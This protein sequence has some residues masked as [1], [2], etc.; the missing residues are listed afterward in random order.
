MTTAIQ[1][2]FPPGPKRRFPGEFLLKMRQDAPAALTE[3]ASQ[4][5]AIGLGLG[6]FK[7][8][9]LSQPQWIHEVMVTRAHEFGKGAGQ[10]VLKRLLGDGLLTS[11]GE[12]HRQQ[13]QLMQPVFQAQRVG[14]FAPQMLGC[15]NYLLSHWPREQGIISAGDEMTRLT[16]Q[17]V[18][19]CLFGSD[20]HQEVGAVRQSLAEAMSLFRTAN[21]P[22][23]H[24]LELLVPSLKQRFEKSRQVLDEVILK[25]I[26][27][28]HRCPKDDLLSRMM[29]SGMSPQLLRDEAMTLFLAGHETTAHA[30]TFA[31]Y[32]LAR[33][34]QI[35][36]Q[37]RSEIDS[38]CGTR[39]L[40][41]EDLPALTD[42]KAALMETLRLY[43]TA[44][45]IGRRALQ[46]VVIGDILVPKDCTV[47]ISQY[48]MHRHPSYFAE[49]ELFWPTR[50][51]HTPRNQLPKG[52]YFPFGAGPRVCIGEHFAWLEML[53]GLGTILQNYQLLD[54]PVD[55][56][57]LKSQV[58]L[59]S[60]Q[61]LP[62]TVRKIRP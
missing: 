7:L 39:P 46:D 47:L 24:W 33:N 43:P 62:I 58:T 23:A 17:I 56:P 4:G 21:L 11:E 42:T 31:L 55:K 5:P 3:L 6:S 10:K 54:C 57:R 15:T 40:S 2:K 1:P 27:E 48:V 61:N 38:V 35:Q 44:W 49:P 45:I 29:A 19:E 51:H 30:L 13:R 16:L 8:I 60:A 32:L 28:H 52:C 34:P 14:Q 18:G 59:S 26:A 36:E 41:L 12:L 22:F 25:M 20:L 37:L 50:W 9:V 53:L